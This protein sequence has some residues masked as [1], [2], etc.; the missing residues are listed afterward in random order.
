MA[1]IDSGQDD[2]ELVAASLLEPEAFSLLFE[3]HST[4]VFKFLARQFDPLAA[5]DLLSE[6]FTTAFRIRHRYDPSFPNAR[7]W[8]LGIAVNMGRHHRRAEARNQQMRYRLQVQ[9]GCTPDE[10]ERA[11][12]RADAVNER[13]RL[14]AALDRLNP[15]YRTVI[16]LFAGF[17]LTY[18]EISRALGVPI[19]T[20]RSRLSRARTALRE[21]LG[22]DGQYQ[23]AQEMCKGVD[24]K[25]T[26]DSGG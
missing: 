25:D 11:D 4:T 19:G 5:G 24:I 18:E 26:G 21:L 1:R 13:A 20:V 14:S 16:L 8:L 22:Q 10:T 15:S 17:D 2:A 12:E 7:S 9:V 6:T 23:A 3:R